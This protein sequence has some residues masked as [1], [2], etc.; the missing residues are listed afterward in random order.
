MVNVYK[1]LQGH[2]KG[3]SQK[4]VVRLFEVSSSQNKNI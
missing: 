2:F 1:A 3:A 4:Y